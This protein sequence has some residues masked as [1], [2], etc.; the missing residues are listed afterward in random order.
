MSPADGWRAA[1]RHAFA[2][3]PE[4]PA[5]PTPAQ[6]QVVERLCVEVVRRHLSTPALLFL[7]VSRPLNYVTAQLLHF[8]EPFVTTLYRGDEYRHLAS[9]LERRGA[10]D[11]LCRRIEALE[12]ECAARQQPAAGA[13]E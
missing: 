11:H 4:G 6:Q 3:D 12:S 5:Q 1:L 8:L 10:I 2:V 7:E 9:F 13:E